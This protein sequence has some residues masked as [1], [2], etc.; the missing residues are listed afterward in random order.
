[1]SLFRDKPTVKTDV[2]SS[3]YSKDMLNN[4]QLKNGK[5]EFN[6]FIRPLMT[7]RLLTSKVILAIR[8]EVIRLQIEDH[9]LFKGL[10]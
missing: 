5:I 1:M 10:L 6:N 8:E 2:N 7:N 4:E 9:K 3:E